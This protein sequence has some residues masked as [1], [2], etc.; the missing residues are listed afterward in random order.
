MQ[1]S[2]R[3]SFRRNDV[4]DEAE[5]IFRVAVVMLQRHLDEDVVFFPF[6]VDGLLIER[7]RTAV[8]ILHEF[9]DAAF[10]VESRLLRLFRPVIGK[11]DAQVFRQESHFTEAHLQGIVVKLD[12]LEDF[13]VREKCDARSMY[14]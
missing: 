13:P 6:A 4:V 14:P 3:A 12:I 10:I 5:D 1:I 11:G 9:P 7:S 8:E 2:M